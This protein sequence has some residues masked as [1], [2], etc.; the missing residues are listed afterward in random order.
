MSIV[1]CPVQLGELKL[2]NYKHLDNTELGLQR[3]LPQCHLLRHPIHHRHRQIHHRHHRF[4]VYL[5][6]L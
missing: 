6:Y 5:D 3:L 4:Q 2:L 1:S